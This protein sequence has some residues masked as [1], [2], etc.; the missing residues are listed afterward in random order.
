MA[1][2]KNASAAEWLLDNDFQVRRAILQI[3]EDLPPGFYA[4]LPGLDDE[5]SA[6][7]PRIYALAHALL[8]ASHLQVGLGTTVEFVGRYQDEIPLSTAELWAL[9]TMLRLACLEL[10][11]AGFARLFPDVPQPFGVGLGW[12]L[13]DATDAT[14]CVSRGIANLGVIATIQWKDYFDQ[15][16]RVE[17]ILNRDP[18]GVY[19]DMDFE[20]RDR[21]RRAVERLAMRAGRTEWD[22]A[23]RLVEQCRGATDPHD[24]VGYWLIGSGRS[25]FEDAIQSKPFAI[26]VLARK[27][28]RHPAAL[29]ACALGV[30]GVTSIALPALYLTHVEASPASWA[31]GIALSLLPASILSVT[32][33]NWLTTL[34]VSPRVLPKLDFEKGIAAEYPTAV[35]MPVIVAHTGDI[36]HVL[37]RLES[38]RLANLDPSLH[39]VLLSDGADADAATLPEDATIERTLVEGIAALNA[40]YADLAGNGRFHLLHRPRF[41]NP[42]QGCWMGWE[43]KRGKLEQFNAYVLTGDIAPF[44]VTTD[45]IA[46]L[47]DLR[48][49]VTADADT[50]LPPGVVG[51]LAG[52]LAHPL[53]QAR[54]DPATGRVA[55]GYTIV[56]PRVEIAPDASGSSLF[57]R[58]FGGDTTI[59]IYSRAVS[60]VYQD[61]LGTGSYI[62]KGIYDVAGFA[63]SLEGRVPENNLLSHDLF[64]GLHGRAALAS[65]IIVFEGFPTGYLDYARRWHRWVRGDWQL[66][67]WLFPRVPGADGRRLDNRLSWFD[68]LKIF[69]NLRRSMVPPSLVALLL[70]GWFVLEGNPWVWTLLGIATPAASLFTDLV[71]GFAGG[72]RRGVLQGTLRRLRD[73]LGRWALAIGFL[74]SDAVIALHAAVVT[75][76]RLA[77]GK[78]L[79]E[80]TSAAHMADHFA[81]RDPRRAAWREMWPSPA[82]AALIAVGLFLADAPTLAVAAPLLFLWFLAPEI[83]IRITRPLLP[84]TEDIG[85]DDRLFL[86]K[87]ARR[88]WLFFETFVRPEDNWLPPDNVQEAPDAATAHRTSPTN[89]GLMLLS[90]L[91]A[92]KLGYIG[93][94]DLAA[95]LRNALDSLDR[96]E[97]YRGHILNWYD[98]R[99][100]EPLEPRYVSTVDSGNLAVSLVVIAEACREALRLPPVRPTTW[101]G[102]DDELALL[103]DALAVETIDPHGKC[104]T[105]VALLQG[106]DGPARSD[107][108]TWPARLAQLRGVDLPALEQ[109]IRETIAGATTA[110]PEALRDVQIWSERVAHHLHGLDHEIQ[111]LLPWLISLDNAPVEAGASAERLRTLLGDSLSQVDLGV[112]CRAAKALIADGLSISPPTPVTTWLHDVAAALDR[113]VAAT[114]ALTG[115]LEEIAVR[116]ADRAHAMDFAFLF[117]TSSRLFNIGYNVSSDRIDPHHYDLLASEARLASFF[118]ISKGDVPFEHWFYLSRPITKRASGLSLVSWNGSMFEYL[119][120]NLFLRSDPETLLGQSD[121]TAVDVQQAYAQAHGIPWG[122]SE[123]GYASMGQDRTYRYHAFGV[124]ALGLRR[125]LERDLVVAPYATAIALAARPGKAL[126]NM[127]DLAALGLIGRYGYYEAVDFTPERVPE[128]DPFAIVRSYMAHHHGMSMAAF[129]NALCGDMLVRWFHADPHIRTVDLLLNERIPWELPA[130]I[131]RLPVRTPPSTPAIAIPPL[132][133]WTRVDA[134]DQMALHIVGNG[135]MASRMSPLGGG[136][137]WRGQALT[138]EPGPWLHLRDSETG[139]SWPGT[140]GPD[141]AADTDSRTVLQSHQIE[142]HR[143]DHGIAVT[144]EIGLAHGDDLEIRRIT[145]VNESDRARRLDLTSYAEVVL[146]PDRDAARHPAFSKLFVGS[147]LLSGLQGLLFW[148]RARDPHDRSPVMIHRVIADEEGLAWHG[149]ETDREAFLGRHG[150]VA[151]AAARHGDSGGST[152]WTLDPVMAIRAGLDIP[153]HGRRQIAFVTVAAGSRTAALEIAE[154]YTTLAALDWALIDAAAHAAREMHEIGLAPDDV[155]NAQLLLAHILGSE[156]RP[157]F[158]RSAAP[159]GSRQDLWSLGVSGDDPILLVRLGDGERTDLLSFSLAAQRLWRRRGVSIDIVATHDGAEGYLE[160]VR[161]HILDVLRASN[162]QELLGQ[163]GGVHLIGNRQVDHG[164][165]ATLERAA[166]VIVEEGAGTLGAQLAAVD[167]MPSRSPRFEPVGGEGETFATS[168]LTCFS[169]LALFNGIGGFAPDDGAYVIHLP[170]GAVTPAPWSNILANKDFGTLVTEAGLGFSW[171]V[172]SGENRLTPWSNDPVRDPQAEIL[173]LRDEENGHFWTTTAQ[174]AGSGSASRIRHGTGYTIWERASEG[175]H[176]E[177]LA[178]VPVDDPVKIVRLRLENLLPRSR[179]ITA[180]FYAEWLLGGASVE[181]APLRV[182]YYDAGSHALMARNPWNDAFATR[183]AF[184]SASQ[185]PHS[186]SVSLSDFLGRARDVRRPDGLVNWDLGGCQ[187]ATA[188]DCCAAYQVHIDIPPG[189]TAEVVFVLGQGDHQA[190]AASLLQ[191]WRDGT[192]V[193]AALQACRSDWTARLGA[194]TVRTPDPAFDMLVNRWL[195]YQAISA[196]LRARAGF[197]QAGGA[198][199]FRDQLQDVLALLHGEPGLARSHILSA[200]AHQFEEGDVLHWWHPPTGAGV[201]TR[202]SD[203]MLWLPFAVSTYVGATGDTGILSEE[204]PFLSAPPLADDEGDRYARFDHGDHRRSLFEH[205]QRA[206]DRGHRLGLHGLPLMGAGDWNDG[207]N[208]IGEQGRGESIWLAWFLIATIDGFVRLCPAAGRPDLVDPWTA[209][210]RALAAAVETAGWDGDWYIRAFDD[211]GRPWGSAADDEC[212]IDSIAQSWAALSGA[213][214]ADRVRRALSAARRHL[215]RDDDRLVRLLWPPFDTTPRDPGYIKAYPPGIRENGGQYTHAAAWLGMAFARVGDGDAAMEVFDR[216]NPISRTRAAEDIRRFRTEPYV[217]AADVAGIAPHIG[218]GGWSWYTGAA[219]WTWRLAVE[220]ILGLRLVAGK[221][222][223]APCPPRGWRTFEA[224]LSRP[225]GTLH[226]RVENPDG[227]STGEVSIRLDGVDAQNGPISFPEHGETI[228]VEVRLSAPVAMPGAPDSR[229]ITHIVSTT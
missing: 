122:I 127:R 92:W 151:A 30:A 148:R 123:S 199:G 36:A 124:P 63:R 16:S 205:C 81:S 106:G 74:V 97:P 204:V 4:R 197:Y 10:L 104:R 57:T 128:G 213:G 58:Y 198:F 23:E 142:T 166:R 66:L 89:I 6:G 194:V 11:V 170:E 100:L 46:A 178:F 115:E 145:I 1:D 117:D 184:L 185:A 55:T 86:R 15:T 229:T 47:R 35:V 223:I 91:T 90:A 125:G 226:I 167:R 61:L 45:D 182:A 160:P 157:A 141:S 126:R 108:A 118:A 159:T 146:A 8:G 179:R 186:L 210:S 119:M 3:R 149:A 42:A 152:G 67:P 158:D 50:R 62:G 78:Q 224:T 154:R 206:V 177:M 48:F 228:E 53:N 209:R 39:F 75:L 24:H 212:M 201:R 27:L 70:A 171:A 218:R 102:L 189:E 98:T 52:T 116:S 51:R 26:D 222:Q 99:T 216:I 83:A 163:R 73:H 107:P 9:P 155:P 143:R 12:A 96:L 207:M 165:I 84:P 134:G 60:D 14:E 19:G 54:F 25:A 121:R 132:H 71:T 111:S 200:A 136:L 76:W 150:D 161:D 33:V 153:A 64:E 196:R 164:R 110:P 49:V 227:L 2:P 129:G 135:R 103:A 203:D 221:L 93:L 172:N 38:H 138:S 144:T 192:A 114:A 175:L 113:G 173:Y 41:Y 88:T 139:A 147:E 176:Q 162:A 109:Q 18:A 68:R 181:P 190:H 131:A 21:Y 180:T 188:D 120:P 94:A 31:L 220:E 140:P 137:S 156:A 219:G 169:D 29:Y 193:E 13:C 187:F 40:R 17:A 82:L 191:R 183:V 211:D 80:W 56:Q 7:R 168:E 72:R 22:V 28:L 133:S 208:R 32:V 214:A 79:L 174:P 101:A 225:T 77:S 20:T 87:I 85:P 105:L 44:S 5:D 130:E 65:D 43:R 59:D 34:L 215:M 202:C 195:P 69:D 37:R 112:A 217:L 95:R